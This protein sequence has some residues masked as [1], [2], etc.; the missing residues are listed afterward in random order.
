MIKANFQLSKESD[1]CTLYTVLCT[2]NTIYCTLG[3]AQNSRI[4]LRA[5]LQ[6]PYI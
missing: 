2:L 1:S 4:F 3:A 6:V 5:E